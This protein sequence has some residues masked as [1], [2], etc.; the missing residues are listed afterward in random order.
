MNFWARRVTNRGLDGG[1]LLL[2]KG[3]MLCALA[4]HD[5]GERQIAPGNKRLSISMSFAI[6]R[7]KPM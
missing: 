3:D 2:G 7:R 4:Q 1:L 5:A 6:L